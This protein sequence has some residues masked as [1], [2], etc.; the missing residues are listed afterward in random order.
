[1][2]SGLNCIALP[3]KLGVNKSDT[4]EHIGIDMR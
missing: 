1:L 2:G 3:E 4:Y